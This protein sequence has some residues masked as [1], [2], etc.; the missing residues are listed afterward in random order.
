M[1]EINSQYDFFKNIEL[2]E[3]AL[4]VD[5]EGLSGI[6]GIPTTTEEGSIRH[7]NGGY[8]SLLF[9]GETATYDDFDIAFSP[10]EKSIFL[11]SST[12]NVGVIEFNQLSVD[13]QWIVPNK[14]GVF[15]LMSDIPMKGVFTT[16]GRP[17]VG[18]LSDG[19]YYMDTTLGLPVWVLSGN[20]I[21]ATGT[22][23]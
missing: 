23:V 8:L 2:T 10:E 5:I 16:A 1:E 19:D 4:R 9:G 12:N 17:D 15:A 6:T 11:K 14:S 21:D 3:G 18:T 20:Y 7:L 22:K 13:S